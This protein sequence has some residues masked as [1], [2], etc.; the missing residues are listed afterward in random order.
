MLLVLSGT[1]I[2]FPALEANLSTGALKIHPYDIKRDIGAFEER[3]AQAKYIQRYLAVDWTNPSW[4]A[5]FDQA[6]GWCRG[7]YLSEAFHPT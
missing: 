7:R 5:F 3:D 4:K 1:G 6:W 2:N